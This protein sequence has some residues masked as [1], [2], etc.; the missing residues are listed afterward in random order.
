MQT[1]WQ[2]VC[3]TVLVAAAVAQNA[4]LPKTEGESLAGRKVVLPDAARGKVAVLV[5]GFTKDSKGPTKAW[6]EKLQ[7]D[8]STEAEFELY[9]LPV[10][11]DVPR[12]MRGMVIS[13]IKKGIP[14]NQRDHFV[15]VL[16]G[17]K[18]LKMFVGYREA[19]DAYVVTLNPAGQV[20][21][22]RHGSSLDASY[23]ALRTQ[24]QPLL[25]HPK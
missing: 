5:F 3:V 22:Q 6:A 20:I 19:D 2:F 23:D 9:Q 12:L 25:K 11:E 4:T 15:P 14:E 18:E 21:D 17:E 7:A 13:G 1:L 10:L 16:Q 8:F 24:I